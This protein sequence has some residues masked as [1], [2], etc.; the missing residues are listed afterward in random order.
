MFS[1]RMRRRARM[2][3][4]GQQL[5][6]AHLIGFDGDLYAGGTKTVDGVSE[7]PDQH[8]INEAA[9]RA[10]A[11]RARLS[12]FPAGPAGSGAVTYACAKGSAFRSAP[13]GLARLPV[14]VSVI[15]S[16]LMMRV[17]AF[18]AR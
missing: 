18:S 1:M 15:R 4:G 14:K 10:S 13:T 11:A 3:V 2:R 9:R 12:H 17:I 8:E 7:V 5:I 6:E 16:S